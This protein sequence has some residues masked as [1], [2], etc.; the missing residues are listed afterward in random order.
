MIAPRALVVALA[1]LT[2]AAEAQSPVEASSSYRELV[3]RVKKGDLSVDFRELRFACLEAEN[4]DPRGDNKDL[5]PMQQAI[6]SK[7]YKKAAKVGESLIDRGFVNIEAHAICSQAYEALKD[8][9]KA[10]FHHDVT[11]ALIRS[12]LSTGDGK[13]K[14]TAFEVIGT[15]E[16]H[17]VMSVLGLPH[18]GSQSLVPGKPHN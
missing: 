15:S 6:R 3:E 5:I 4:C 17:L 1:I 13:A 10:K 7:D 14:E 2:I 9:S 18:L 8:S 16:E 11:S 12:I